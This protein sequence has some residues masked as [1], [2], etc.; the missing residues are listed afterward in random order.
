MSPYRL[1][2]WLVICWTNPVL[3]RPDLAKPLTIPTRNITK[4]VSAAKK[5][6]Q[7][8]GLKRV[9][10]RLARCSLLCL[11]WPGLIYPGKHLWRADRFAR[12]PQCHQAGSLIGKSH[13]EI[14]PWHHG[15]TCILH[16]IDENTVIFQQ[17]TVFL[18]SPPKP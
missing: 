14:W 3:I 7:I 9:R 6:R 13:R 10:N 16:G 17:Y 2:L 18:T 8:K 5:S 15:R 11:V 12:F 4:N 1:Q